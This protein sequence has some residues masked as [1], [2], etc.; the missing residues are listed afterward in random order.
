M[1]IR[2]CKIYYT[3]MKNLHYFQC[4]E[5]IVCAGDVTSFIRNSKREDDLKEVRQRIPSHPTSTLAEEAV[6]QLQ[7]S[8]K[9]IAGK[10]W[11]TDKNWCSSGVK[12]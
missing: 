7:A 2:H 4:V 3:K 9:L 1:K 10:N 5:W 12:F 6:E 8:E 11:K